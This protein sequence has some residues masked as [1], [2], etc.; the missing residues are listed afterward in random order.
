[1]STGLLTGVYQGYNPP[2]AGGGG[3]IAFRA[4]SATSTDFTS[5][6]GPIINAPAGLQ[7]GD[8]ILI[9]V[10][11][12]ANAAFQTPGN[13][14]ATI[15]ELTD[16]AGD[17]RYLAMYKIA[18]GEG[19]TWT[20]SSLLL[21]A[22][23]GIAASVAYTGVDQISPLSG[24]AT[25]V[26]PAATTTPACSTMTPGHDNAM[27]IGVFGCDPATGVKTGTQGSGWTE[28]ADFG[29]SGDGHIFIEEMLQTSA[30]SVAAS[31]TADTSDSYGCIQF[32]LK[33]A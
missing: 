29:R 6:T 11:I 1:L 7:D 10:A 13:G 15:H 17:G 16:G 9:G 18:S 30:S 2:A 33:P 23:A 22:S 26:A 3:G 31:F 5:T 12:A 32:A 14:F 25:E 27:V 8:F 4:N 24:T 21:S 20:F 28:R 19:A